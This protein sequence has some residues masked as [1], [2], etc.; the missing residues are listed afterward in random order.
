MRLDQALVLRNLYSTRA[1]AVAAI[2]GGLVMVNG[3][4]AKKPSQDVAESDVIVGGALPYS[5]GRGSL[6]LERALECFKINPMGMLCLDVGASTGGFT[7]ALLNHGASRVYAV[8]VGTNQL[9]PELRENPRVVS[10]EKTD[11]RA[12]PVQSV[13]DLIVI[14]VSFVSLVNI[15]ECLRP[16]GAKNII[17][18]IKPQFEVPREVAAKCNGVIKSP[19]LHKESIARVVAAFEKC[20][21]RS[22]GVTESPVKGGSGNTEF[23]ACFEVE[24]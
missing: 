13:V 19:E 6:K 7:E 22:V 3:V 10:L 16:W 12:L 17:A 1:R 20:G 23:L 2:K 18:L 14:D 21:F 8:D 11:I 15:V 9:I 24:K 4:P 5:S